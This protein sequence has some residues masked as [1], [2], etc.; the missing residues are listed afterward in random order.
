MPR[1]F[2][3]VL[4]SLAAAATGVWCQDAA[5]AK[6]LTNCSAVRSL[7]RETAARGLPVQLQGV[8][9]VVPA[10]AGGGFTL[11]DGVGLW[12]ARPRGEPAPNRPA[13]LKAGDW[14]EIDGVTQA[15][16]FLPSVAA[17][18]V[19]RLGTR[20]LPPPREISH[21]DL[22]TGA[23]DGQRV[24]VHAVVQSAD[25]GV[26]DDRTELRLVA[27]AN[28]MRFSYALFAETG[29]DP[30]SL[31]DA[32]VRLTGV[33]L[34]YFNARRQFLGVRIQSN[35]AAD[36]RVTTPAPGDAFSVP[37]VT[38]S[39]GILF[40]AQ[41]GSPHRRRVRGVVT[42]CAPGKYF[43]LQEGGHALRVNTRQGQNLQPG[44]L[45]EAAG[46]FS[47]EHHKAEMLD[48]SFRRIGQAEPPVP[49][50]VTRERLLAVDP[51]SAEFLSRDFDDYLISVRGTLVSVDPG[52]SASP[53]KLNFSYDGAL[54]QAELVNAAEAVRLASVRLGSEIRVGG[55]CVLSFSVSRPVVEWPQP[56]AMRLLLRGAADVEI[57]HAASWWTA[58]RLWSALVFIGLGL[59]LALTWVAL[60]RRTVTR[61]SRELSEAMRERRDAAVEFESTLRERNRLAADLHDTLEQ[62]LTGIAHQLEASEALHD[63]GPDRSR[64]H[65]TLARQVLD[66]SREDLR[67]SIWNLRINPL[68]AADLAG[69][70]RELSANRS[71]GIATRIVVSCEGEPRPLPDFVAGNLL[72]LVQEGITNALKHAA[73]SQIDLR[74]KFAMHAVTVEVADNGTGFVVGDAAG[75]K[76]GHFGLQ[77]MRERMK[78]LGGILEIVS[79]RG[80]GTVIR[81]T[82]PE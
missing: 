82:V 4:A 51:G 64:Q 44:D 18:R 68:E 66:R 62:S 29:V 57:L 80:A 1:W 10:P 30:E 41:G 72:L 23:L 16:H 14:V 21:L 48:A 45:V 81:V 55:I 39:D 60:L 78:R 40:S 33:F 65:L 11:D 3:L 61:R 47:L 15:G 2:L 19:H 54:V 7:S 27:S 24:T 8:I 12:I 17:S 58:E 37:E 53:P 50:P 74:V 59:L 76:Q 20:P 70:L 69:A 73:P 56:V 79:A 25:R 38:L 6:P 43:F 26:R 34:A 9:T 52:T 35:D 77:G 75:P 36:V 46:F 13:D 42:L 32:E 28:G 71:A 63:R 22:S 5:A 67:R 49:L 31:I